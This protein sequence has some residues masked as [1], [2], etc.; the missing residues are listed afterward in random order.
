MGGKYSGSKRETK[1]VKV[2]L[3][4]FWRKELSVLVAVSMVTRRKYILLNLRN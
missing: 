1:C 3:E 2:G 4:T